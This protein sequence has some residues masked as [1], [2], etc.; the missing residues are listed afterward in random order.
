MKMKD[1]GDR[2]IPAVVRV[3]WKESRVVDETFTLFS[4]SDERQNIKNKYI[5]QLISQSNQ[6]VNPIAG[7]DHD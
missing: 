6:I 4:V 1:L 5:N 2:D 7:L 3:E